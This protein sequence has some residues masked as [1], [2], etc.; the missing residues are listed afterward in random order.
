ME[1][2]IKEAQNRLIGVPIVISLVSDARYRPPRFH[3]YPP[4]ENTM[5]TERLVKS[6][7]GEGG[8][9]AFIKSATNNVPSVSFPRNVHGGRHFEIITRVQVVRINRA[10]R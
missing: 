6:G 5:V 9:G 2:G 7:G 3:E 8:E 1:V 4:L 10:E